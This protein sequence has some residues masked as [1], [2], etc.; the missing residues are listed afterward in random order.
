MVD[1]HLFSCEMRAT[2]LGCNRTQGGT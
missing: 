2:I 1:I